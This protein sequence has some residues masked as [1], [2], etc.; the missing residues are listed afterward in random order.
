[1]VSGAYT[2]VSSAQ[3]FLKQ[4]GVA[5]D[6]LSEDLREVEEIELERR[7]RQRAAAEQ[8]AA[9]EKEEL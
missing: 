6:D 7:L 1:M 2:L 8:H 9:A 4:G 5:L 3:A